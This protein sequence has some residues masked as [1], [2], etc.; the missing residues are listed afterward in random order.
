MLAERGLRAQVE[1][2]SCYSKLIMKNLYSILLVKFNSAQI[3]SLLMPRRPI[4]LRLLPT[5]LSWLDVL[6]PIHFFLQTAYVIFASMHVNEVSRFTYLFAYSFGR[7]MRI[8]RYLINGFV[9][10][11][12]CSSLNFSKHLFVVFFLWLLVLRKQLLN[13]ASITSLFLCWQ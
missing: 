10:H 4:F 2:D 6:R 5:L 12:I 7:N 13:A 8:L 1:T 9:K 3:P 11:I